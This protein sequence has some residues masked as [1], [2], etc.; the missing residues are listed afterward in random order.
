MNRNAKCLTNCKEVKTLR[1]KVVLE[2][3]NSSAGAVPQGGYRSFSGKVTKYYR[4][5][6]RLPVY[7]VILAVTGFPTFLF[8]LVKYLLAKQNSRYYS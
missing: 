1:V 4:K 8:V 6:S 3:S 7:Q 2:L 5:M